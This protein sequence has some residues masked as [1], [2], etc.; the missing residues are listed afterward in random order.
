MSALSAYFRD[1]G[2]SKETAD[3]LRAFAM[4]QLGL[5]EEDMMILLEYL[6]KR[7]TEVEGKER[8]GTV[9]DVT[10][11]CNLICKHCA[12]NANVVSGRS[13]EIHFE[14]PTEDVKTIVDKVHEYAH[15]KEYQIFL[16]FGGGEPTLR[17]DFKDLIKYTY[18]KIG[19][20]SIGFN[21]NGTIFSEDDLLEIQKYVN[22]I[23]ISVDG[24]EEYHN[25]WRK[26]CRESELANPYR[27]AIEL[28]VA[29][30]QH[31][32][33]Q[34]KIEVTSIA[35]KG[36][37]YQLPRFMSYISTLGVQN[38]SIH[39]AMPVGRMAAHLS[40]IPDFREYAEL[41]V[42][43]A[44]IKDSLPM[45]DLHIHHSLESIY[46]ALLLGED[47]HLTYLPTSS[48]RHSLGIDPYGNVYFDPWCVVKPY[49]ILTAGSLLNPS[50]KLADMI[51][52]GGTAI[53][54]ANDLSKK[55]LRCRQCRMNCGGGMRFNAMANY[56]A[57]LSEH[58]KAEIHESHLLA[59]LSQI[60]PACPL[61][62]E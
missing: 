29:A 54:I 1:S 40:Q 4:K 23:E 9:F 34:P 13:C 16:M 18:N 51:E 60:D 62:E 42:A 8:F 2:F 21:T 3:N 5:T 25:R 26:P 53:K 36:N 17:P 11:H 48:G 19:R 50:A 20:D 43:V 38:Y 12:V 14:M 15:S 52:N 6:N 35:T 49:N 56:I 33:L 61:Y 22:T 37:I 58:V 10:H 46:S 59:G 55:R 41:F 57:N 28:I 32:K 30:I 27:K 44:R 47:L 24:F 39:R 7:K 31:K 45:R